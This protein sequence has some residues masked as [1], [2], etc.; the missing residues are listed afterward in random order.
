MVTVG[1]LVLAAGRT[2]IGSDALHGGEQKCHEDDNDYDHD[3]K[4]DQSETKTTGDVGVMHCSFSNK[5]TRR[6][7]EHLS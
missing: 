5:L 7:C 2:G 3:Q 6:C 1:L 4:F